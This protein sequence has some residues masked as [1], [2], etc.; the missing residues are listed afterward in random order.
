MSVSLQVSIGEAIDKLSI[1]DIKC[2]KI[3]DERLIDVQKEYTYLYET[4]KT[5]V[6]SY[7]YYYDLLYKTNLEI[8]EVQDQIREEQLAT[9]ERDVHYKKIVDLNDSRFLIKN[10]LNLLCKSEFKEQK[11][12]KKRKLFLVMHLG[13]GDA[14]TMNGAIRYV[15]LFYD[16]VEIL[17][18]ERNYKNVKEMFADDPSI[19]VFPIKD[20]DEMNAYKTFSERPDYDVINSGFCH[21]ISSRISHSY[22]KDTLPVHT[23]GSHFI[24][25][26]YKRMNVDFSVYTEY[27]Y[28]PVSERAQE[29]FNLVKGYK[30][31]FCHNHA[32]DGAVEIS[33]IL[34]YLSDS[35]C[36]VVNPNKNM[37]SSEHP[38]YEITENLVGKAFLDYTCILQN[39]HA[40]Y[41]VDSSFFACTLPM[42]E[43]GLIKTSRLFC[44]PRS[45]Y[46]YE[47]FT[48]K[49][50]YLK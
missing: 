9:Q 42:V 39:A 6:D 41:V 40:L 11:G 16:Q 32:S 5:F 27:F 37:Y 7:K 21:P 20:K 33:E 22:F 8:W 47:N 24:H 1:L 48:N 35:S 43:R 10:K 49:F 4:L 12:Y 29:L 15:S 28:V 38:F 18:K 17:S 25:E 44:K 3:Q 19:V 26:F 30:L 36:L 14:F 46:N 31:V 50:M 34:P 23:G 13:L 2:H 45:Q